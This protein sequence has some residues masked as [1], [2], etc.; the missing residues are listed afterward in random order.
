MKKT[1]PVYISMSLEILST[2][3]IETVFLRFAVFNE[4][5]DS[6]SELGAFSRKAEHH[7]EIPIL[8]P[9]LLST[10]TPASAHARWLLN[11]KSFRDGSFPTFCLEV[12]CLY[13]LAPKICTPVFY[14][15]G[16]F[17]KHWA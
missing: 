11:L 14:C 10:W 6:K 17:M 9:I 12:I 4:K 2:A 16:E 1:I 5:D 15:S 13:F 8:L 7:C 3:K